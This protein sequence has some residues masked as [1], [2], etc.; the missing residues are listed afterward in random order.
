MAQFHV[1]DQVTCRITTVAGAGFADADYT[2]DDGIVVFL[3][4]DASVGA[5]NGPIPT[6][7][8][9]PAAPAAPGTE[10]HDPYGLLANRVPAFG[11]PTGV[12]STNPNELEYADAAN[13]TVSGI[14]AVEIPAGVTVDG[15]TIGQRLG[16]VVTN[17]PG[18]NDGLQ[19]ITTGNDGKGRVIARNG[20]T[21]YWDI[22]AT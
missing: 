6:I 9:T 13:V 1:G 5:A 17:P 8:K 21:V 11:D 4:N 16:Y 7:R 15:N 20:Q 18:A 19:P 3:D 12:S 10:T 22:R 14:L 2:S